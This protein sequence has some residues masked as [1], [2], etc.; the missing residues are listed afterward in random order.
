M[1]LGTNPNCFIEGLK[2]VVALATDVKDQWLYFTDA[3]EG[4]IFRA[5]L[6][7]GSQPV[8]TVLYGKC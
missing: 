5:S 7:P 8:R 4:K 3:S 6:A 2:F 1:T